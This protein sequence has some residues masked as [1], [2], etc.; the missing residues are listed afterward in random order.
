V[1]LWESIAVTSKSVAASFLLRIFTV[2]AYFF[3]YRI[4]GRVSFRRQSSQEIGLNKI[5]LQCKLRENETHTEKTKPN[6]TK[7]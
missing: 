1:G 7:A 5:K 6:K 4:D 3:F 2:A